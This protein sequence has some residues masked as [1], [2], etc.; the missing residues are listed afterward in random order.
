MAN[1]IKLPPIVPLVYKGEK[2]L[3]NVQ[4]A[5]LFGVT[6]SSIVHVYGRHKSAIEKGV[7]FY[8]LRGKDF[9]K[10]KAENLVVVPERADGATEVVANVTGELDSP[11]KLVTGELD[12]PAKLIKG[13]VLKIWTKSGIFKLSKYIRTDNAKL[14]YI[15][16]TQGYFY[17]EPASLPPVKEIQDDGASIYCFEMS[18]G[19]VKIG[20]SNNVPYRAKDVEYRTRLKV[21]NVFYLTVGSRRKAFDIEIALHKYFAAQCVQREFFLIDFNEACEQIKAI[22]NEPEIEE[23]DE[24]PLFNNTDNA[25]SQF[26]KLK[27]LIEQTEDKN[28]KEKLIR[29]AAK[30]ILGKDF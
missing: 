20:I 3:T 11:A 4:I 9:N 2:V 26:D 23:Q 14:I 5:E 24:F 12:S 30:L 15:S 18:N 25:D 8:D 17:T 19:T 21:T 16:L 13:S 10:F 6:K 1:Q 7:D 22:I 29:V 28:L 27:F